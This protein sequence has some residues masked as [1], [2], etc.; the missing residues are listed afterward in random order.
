MSQSFES[1]GGDDRDQWA[2]K[3]QAK[4]AIPVYAAYWRVNEEDILE[5][6]QCRETEKTAQILDADGGTDKV[7]QPDTGIRHIA[8]R[9]RTQH[10]KWSTDFS[11]RTSTYSDADT[12]YDKLLNAHRNGGNVPAIYS[13]GVGA[14]TT[15]AGCL[16]RGFSAIHFIDLPKFLNRVDNNDLEAVSKQSNKDG[17]AALYYTVDSLRRYGVINDSISGDI[18]A[19]AWLD[20]S[21][22][23]DFPTAPGIDSTGQLDLFEFGGGK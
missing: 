10:E 13:F 17:S 22:S 5:V 7:V 4:Y 1:A 8:Q 9:F 15:K 14:A 18:L 3:M 23:D 11:I 2:I 6:D 21:V 16:D 20:S 19:S 12:E